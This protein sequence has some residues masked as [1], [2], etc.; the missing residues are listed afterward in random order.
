MR[1]VIVG[2][3]HAGIELSEALRRAHHVGPITIIDAQASYPYQRPP[4]SKEGLKMPG[5]EALPLRHSTFFDENRIDLIRGIAV[6]AV[7]RAR[8]RVTLAGGTEVPYDALVLAVGAQNRRPPIESIG[9]AGVFE[10]R[11]DADAV[12]ISA[13]LSRAQRVVVIGSGFIGLEVAASARAAGKQ[14][15]VISVGDRVM[16]R[17]VS[18]AVSEHVARVHRDSGVD[19]RLRSGVDRLEV[20]PDGH[21]QGVVTSDGE[22][23]G[24][25]AVVIGVGVVSRTELASG[26]GLAVDN[27]ILV[28][29]SLRTDDAHIWAIG[30]CAR[31]YSR[32]ALNRFESVQNATDQ[33]RTLA[34]TLTG[35]EREYTAVPWFYSVQGDLRIQI[36][37]TSPNTDGCRVSGDPLTGKFSVLR[38]ESG[39]LRCVESINDA[40]AH[41]AAR[42]VLSGNES[43]SISEVPIE[44]FNL[45]L[46]LAAAL[47]SQ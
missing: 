25:D 41:L 21:V 3:G 27:G 24:A 28:S 12:A 43:L 6:E 33:A 17:A 37:G 1:V 45:K 13:G 47:T 10:L 22:S 7:D 26:A 42:K 34:Y 2:G 9:I 40:G 30:D 8:R 29:A 15:T 4:L 20:S 31:F 5:I 44:G 35:E 14:V 23:I 16:S 11:T 39:V 46:H 32:G 36:A 19:I 18:P 38:F